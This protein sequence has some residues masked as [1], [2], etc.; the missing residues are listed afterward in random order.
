MWRAPPQRLCRFTLFYMGA[1]YVTRR[2]MSH[3]SATC[4]VKTSPRLPE[5]AWAVVMWVT[6]VNGMVSA[7]WC[8]TSNLT[9]LTYSLVVT[10]VNGTVYAMGVASQVSSSDMNGGG[11]V[12][13]W[14]R[15]CKRVW[16]RP[17]HHYRL[18]EGQIRRG[19][20]CM[21]IHGTKCHPFAKHAVCL[22][23]T[24]SLRFSRLS[25]WIDPP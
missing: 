15:L 23:Q 24:L 21:H 17:S 13:V 22:K 10:V 7:T 9:P 8:S 4:G 14:D 19:S 20:L 25:C 12:G 5:V 3:V 2:G 6:V 1:V 18:W 11:D 16:S